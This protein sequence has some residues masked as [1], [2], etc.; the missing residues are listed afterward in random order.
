MTNTPPNPGTPPVESHRSAPL[1][2]LI[3]SLGLLAFGGYLMWYGL[4][5]R[6]DSEPLS[7]AGGVVPLGAILLGTFLGRRVHIALAVLTPMVILSAA[8][9]VAYVRTTAIAEVRS[10]RTAARDASRVALAACADSSMRATW[11]R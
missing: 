3:V 11:L 9:G 1:W 10:E 4:R 2:M 7:I 5:S 6:A 8:A